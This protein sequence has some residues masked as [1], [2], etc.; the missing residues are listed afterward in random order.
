MKFISE[1]IQDSILFVLCLILFMGIV[2]LYIIDFL[3]EPIQKLF[4]K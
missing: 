2:I 1:A 3:T 4:R